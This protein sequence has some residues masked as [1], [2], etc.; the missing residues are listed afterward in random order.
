MKSDEPDEASYGRRRVLLAAGSTLGVGLAGCIDRL[1]LVGADD[2][3]EETQPHVHGY[4]FV[5]I[6]GNEISFERSKYL[7]GESDRVTTTFHFHAHDEPNRWHMEGKR[8]VLAAALDALPDM[9]YRLEDG[10]NV[11]QIDGQTYSAV[12][13]NTD[14]AITA[15]GGAIDPKTYRLK[16]GDVITIRITTVAGTGAGTGEDERA[17][18]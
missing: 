2:E 14:I 18:E 4:L 3:G 1:P 11:L 15:R 13:T 8:L 9:E 17:S 7:L 5:L 12:D 6:D 16:S 10:R